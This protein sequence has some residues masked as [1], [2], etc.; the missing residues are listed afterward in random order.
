MTRLFMLALSAAALTACAGLPPTTHPLF[1]ARPADSTAQ[2]PAAPTI[3][4]EMNSLLLTLPGSTVTGCFVLTGEY[5]RKGSEIEVQLRQSAA[6][7][8]CDSP[9][10][11]FIT[12]IGPLP[13]GTY[14]VTVMLDGKPLIRAERA[15]IS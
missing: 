14:E 15:V 7:T 9:P 13:P 6:T 12:R 5:V 2:D 4:I 8:T 1:I 11:P 3:T 10:R